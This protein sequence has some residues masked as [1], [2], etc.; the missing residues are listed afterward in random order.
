MTSPSKR[1]HRGL[2]AE[3]PDQQYA[4]EHGND[5]GRKAFHAQRRLGLSM[6]GPC[7]IDRNENQPDQY[8]RQRRV[9]QSEND[10]DARDGPIKG[11]VLSILSRD[12]IMIDHF[13]LLH[14]SPVTRFTRASAFQESG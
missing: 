12:Q 9:D 6:R 10:A 4:D 5:R 14:V 2:I 7:N 3:N 11:T 1:P 8:P 13:P